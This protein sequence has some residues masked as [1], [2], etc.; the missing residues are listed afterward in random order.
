ME[1]KTKNQIQA[2][3]ATIRRHVFVGLLGLICILNAGFLISESGRFISGISGQTATWGFMFAGLIEVTGLILIIYRAQSLVGYIIRG[4]LLVGIFGTITASAAYFGISPILKQSR[5][6]EIDSLKISALQ[7]EVR[8]LNADTQKLTGQKTNLAITAR[9][10][11]EANTRLQAAISS[12]E[13]RAYSTGNQINR[14]GKIAIIVLLRIILQGSNWTICH[15]LNCIVRSRRKPHHSQAL[16]RVEPDLQLPSMPIQVSEKARRLLTWIKARGQVKRQQLLCSRQ[17][18]SAQE[19]D[20]G[21]NELIAAG[22]VI[23]SNGTGRKADIK[24]IAGEIS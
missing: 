15:W 8:G 6:G 17:L 19:Y 1:N 4:L 10:K 7:E 18:E 5:I 24:Y 20:A 22:A 12:A 2:I 23:S 11:R 13:K 14:N 9:K 3:T 21:L 16:E